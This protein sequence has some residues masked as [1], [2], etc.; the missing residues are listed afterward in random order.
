[1]PATIAATRPGPR[2]CRSSDA[3]T[4]GREGAEQQLALDRDV[5]DAGAL[6]EHAAQGAE[7]ERD[8]ERDRAAEQADHADPAA[9]GGPAQEAVI[10]SS[11]KT[12]TSH[13]GGRAGGQQPPDGL[14]R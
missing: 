11:A 6:A 14:A 10:Q 5:D 7:D 4:R 3:A 8:G 1:M 2:R 9:G 12:T 13:S